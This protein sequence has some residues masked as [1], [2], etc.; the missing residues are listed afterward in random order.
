MSGEVPYISHPA[1]VENVGV[2]AGVVVVVVVVVSGEVGDAEL[3]QASPV[4]AIKAQM[5]GETNRRMPTLTGTH[6][7]EFKGR[8]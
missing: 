6:Q 1:T 7:F 4:P 5:S 8:G 2:G 3:P